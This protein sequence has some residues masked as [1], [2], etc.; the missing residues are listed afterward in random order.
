MICYVCASA[1]RNTLCLQGGGEGLGI[2]ES[3][4]VSSL[5]KVSGVRWK[6]RVKDVGSAWQNPGFNEAE[7]H[8]EVKSSTEFVFTLSLGFSTQR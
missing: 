3:R 4:E 7:A 6:E 2:E 8:T 1:S 5:L